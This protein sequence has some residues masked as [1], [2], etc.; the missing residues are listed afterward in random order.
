MDLSALASILSPVSSVLG[1]LVAGPAGAALAPQII[2]ALAGA[3][4][5][6]ATP[7]ALAEKAKSDPDAVASA[8]K[9]VET[10]HGRTWQEIEAQ[11]IADVNATYRAELQQ[12]SRF[13]KWARPFN[14]WIIGGAT[15]SYAACVVAATVM[16]LWSRDSGALTLLL[17]HAVD[18][19]L[20]L[21]PCGAVAG[22][23]AWGRTREKTAGL[24][25]GADGLVQAAG[26]AAKAI[27][28][29]G[30]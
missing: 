5:T 17:R 14:I 6:D 9:Q 19:S 21:T 8:A 27:K 18:V 12:E 30:R 25:A 29:G 15:G 20:A 4:G 26:A 13:V 10:S 7:E 22:V 28:K 3:L 23:T 24:A 1:G 2:G 11:V 16:F